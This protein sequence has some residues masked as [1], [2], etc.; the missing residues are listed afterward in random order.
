MKFWKHFFTSLFTP[1]DFRLILLLFGFLFLFLGIRAFWIYFQDDRTVAVT[2]KVM[3][4]E[5][6]LNGHPHRPHTSFNFRYEYQYK[7]KTYS[8]SRYHYKSED[9]HAEAVA[10]YRPGDKIKVFLNPEDPTEVIIEK[11][12][13]W[14]N[15]I[16]IL[17]SLALLYKIL[18]IHAEMVKKEQY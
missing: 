1:V 15:L 11:G 9:G 14:L 3:L 16:W 18:T 17:V 10:R 8:S 2:G 12:W 4:S 5:K 6:R 7:G 13:S